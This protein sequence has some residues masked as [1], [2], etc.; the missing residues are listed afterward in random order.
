MTDSELKEI[1]LKNQDNETQMKYL[2]AGEEVQHFKGEVMKI[3]IFS[4]YLSQNGLVV[5]ELDFELNF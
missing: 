3:V 4:L 1:N 2:P 5:E